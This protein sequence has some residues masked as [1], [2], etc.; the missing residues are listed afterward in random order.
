M[1]ALLP[2]VPGKVSGI[3]GLDPMVLQ[4]GECGATT[5]QDRR[6]VGAFI[7]LA[8]YHFHICE[9]KGGIRRCPGCLEATKKECPSVRCKS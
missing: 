8:G 9:G 3:V 4:C 2:T 6:S 5:T 1:T 7:L